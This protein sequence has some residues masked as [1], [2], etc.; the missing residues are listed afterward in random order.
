MSSQEQK[1]T[2]YIPNVHECGGCKAR[3]IKSEGGNIIQ[4]PECGGFN[5]YL[6]G[7]VFSSFLECHNHI[8]E[9][10]DSDITY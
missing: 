4:C 3:Y 5:C 1:N 7:K 8:A 9:E 10:H 2:E 6:C